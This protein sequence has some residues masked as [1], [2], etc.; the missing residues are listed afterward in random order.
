MYFGFIRPVQGAI[1]FRSIAEEVD[2]N[3]ELKEMIEESR[4]Q[5]KL[6]QGMS[7]SEI[8]KSLSPRDFN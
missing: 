5:Y 2:N 1:K 7:T 3:P 8:V 6:G 4:E